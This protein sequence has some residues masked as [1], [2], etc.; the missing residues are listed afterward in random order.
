MIGSGIFIVSCDI[1]RTVGSP[2]YMLLVWAISGLL[3]LMAAISY[4][5][6]AAMM[7]HA[8]GQYV[9]LREAYNP[10]FGFLYGWTLFLV[11]QCGTIA[12]V[13]V[14]F[15]KYLGVIFPSV[16]EQNNILQVGS[17]K[18]NSVHIVSIVTIIFLT[19]INTLGIKEGKWVQNIFTFLKV[20]ILLLFIIVGL[21]YGK[22][23]AIYLENK[24]YF[25]D[26]IRFENGNFI[27]IK[28]ISLIVAIGSAMI[29]AL[30]AADAWYN[31]TFA[32]SE[33]INAKRT[34]PLS[35][36]IGTL[37]VSVLYYLTNVVYLN[38]LPLRGN[39][40]GMTVLERGIQFA[41][42]DRIGTAS[43][44]RMTG[45]YSVIIM[46]IVVVISTFGCNNG[47]ILSG[48][49][50]YYA[51]ARDGIFFKSI[52]KLNKKKVPAQALILQC[53]WSCMLCLSG[54]Y[55]QLLDYVM[56]AVLIF[57]ILTIGAIFIL[58]RKKPE[59]HRPYKT[60]GYPYLPIIYIIIM[61]IILWI[62]IIDNPQYTGPGL[63]IIIMGIPVYYYW[64]SKEKRTS[65]G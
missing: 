20:F 36:I 34:I 5:E 12:A 37:I 6:L 53:I 9:Y 30:F 28:G 14:A 10:L 64:K 11:I 25:W 16:S 54:T 31:I 42:E 32:S 40:D 17:A 56:F 39:P 4:G 57:F 2:G 23:R 59:I 26:A 47:I 49:R 24:S 43:M 65:R 22:D 45:S 55:S 52:G 62:L 41:S 1:A 51:M 3:T 21:Y 18:I 38:S 19:W 50:V 27:E 44:S 7:P 61:M 33:V 8:G 29:G 15:S 46:A 63:L 58:R 13:A 35:L 60:P 48:A